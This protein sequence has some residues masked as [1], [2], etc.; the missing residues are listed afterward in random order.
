[1]RV[2]VATHRYRVP[3]VCVQRRSDP[4]DPIVTVPPLVCIEV[5]SPE[6]RINRVQEELA[7]YARM[8]VENIWLLDPLAQRAW[9]ATPDGSIQHVETE[10]TI[11]NTPIRISLAEV[12]AE[13]DDMRTPKP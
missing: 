12:F 11:P 9:V 6:D 2:Q 8:G 5:L 1:M 7:D 13:L 4:D 10:L 3:D